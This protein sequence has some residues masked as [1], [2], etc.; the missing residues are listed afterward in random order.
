MAATGLAIGWRPDAGIG[1]VLAGFAIA[2]LFSYALTWINACLGMAVSSPESAQGIVFI[3]IFPLA[4]V[5][6][7]LFPRKGMPGVAGGDRQLEPGERGGLSRAGR[8]SA[9]RT[10]PPTINAWPMQH[11]VAAALGW[12]ILILV[13]AIPLADRLYR[14]R[15]RV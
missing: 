5:S 9:T 15:T 1:S 14:H 6:N 4:F 10:R 2:L 7:V 3:F 8:C 12:S 13:V 11:P